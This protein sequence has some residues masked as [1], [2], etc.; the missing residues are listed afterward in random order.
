MDVTIKNLTPVERKKLLLMRAGLSQKELA[1]AVGFT[2][3]M[4][5]Y[6]VNG[7]RNS[8]TLEQALARLAVKPTHARL[9]TS[10]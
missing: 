6:W 2:T 10:D 8:R 9:R 5:S 1:R 3:A 4:V 7:K